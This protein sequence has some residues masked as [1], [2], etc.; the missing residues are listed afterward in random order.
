MREDVEPILADPAHDDRTHL[1]RRQ[2]L[3]RQS[4]RSRCTD[5]GWSHDLRT[6]VSLRPLCRRRSVELR[7]NDARTQDRHPDSLSGELE[8]QALRVPDTGVLRRDV[9]TDRELRD[10]DD[11]AERGRVHDVRLVGGAEVRQEGVDRLGAA[12]SAARRRARGGSRA[13]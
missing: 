5:G 6:A 12:E 10:G 13:A 7:L 11:A 9:D 1:F 8:A 3:R 2:R 4:A